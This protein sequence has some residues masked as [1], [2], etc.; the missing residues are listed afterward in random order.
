[1]VP[2]IGHNHRLA[3]TGPG[4]NSETKETTP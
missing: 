2:P 3:P 4:V 1:V